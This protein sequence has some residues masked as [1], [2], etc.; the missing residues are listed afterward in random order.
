MPCNS[1]LPPLTVLIIAEAGIPVFDSNA[2]I[3]ALV[4]SKKKGLISR[5]ILLHSYDKNTKAVQ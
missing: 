3:K 4:F 2:E 5:L 1:T